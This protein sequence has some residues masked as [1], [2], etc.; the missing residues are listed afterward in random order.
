ML[1]RDQLKTGQVPE[2]VLI[3]F[4]DSTIAD[5]YIDKVRDQIK[6]RPVCVSFDGKEYVYIVHL[7]LKN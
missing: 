5:K 7:Y 1:H 3:K 2:V 6:V 4:D